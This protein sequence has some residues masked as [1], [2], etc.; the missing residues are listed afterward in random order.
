MIAILISEAMHILDFWVRAIP[1]PSGAAILN[2]GVQWALNLRPAWKNEIMRMVSIFLKILKS[3][4]AAARAHSPSTHPR[5]H[6]WQTPP[7]GNPPAG[8]A[9]HPC[10]EANHPCLEARACSARQVWVFCSVSRNRAGDPQS[11]VSNVV[12]TKAGW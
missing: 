12:H 9:S 1:H 10:P 6:G 5:D 8:F 2:S 11:L 7:D 3:G 4:A